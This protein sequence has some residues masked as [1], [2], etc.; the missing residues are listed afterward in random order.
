MVLTNY[1]SLDGDGGEASF[2]SVGWV[3]NRTLYWDTAPASV[4]YPFTRLAWLSSVNAS[5]DYIYHQLSDDTLVE[6][7]DLVQ[8]GWKTVNISISS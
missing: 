7:T 4:P 8:F 5:A 6:E 1:H 2:T 3:E